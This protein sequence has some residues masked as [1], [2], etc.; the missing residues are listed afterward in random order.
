MIPMQLTAKPTAVWAVGF[1]TP[2][3]G[4][5]LPLSPMAKPLGPTS[6]CLDLPPLLAPLVSPSVEL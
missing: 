6:P 2:L 5:P 4:L 1:L 3:W